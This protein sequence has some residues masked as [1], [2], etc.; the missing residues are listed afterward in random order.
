M[1]KIIVLIPMKKI[2]FAKSRLKNN[3]SNKDRKFLVF[4]LLDTL[5]KK[6]IVIKENNIEF[7]IA[8]VTHCNEIKKLIRENFYKK[9]LLINDERSKTLSHSMQVASS[10]ALKH[11]YGWICFLPG[12]LCSP[13][14]KDII[15]LLEFRSNKEEMTICPSN[16]YG[17]NALLLSIPTKFK[18]SF[19]KNSFYKHISFSK[20]IGLKTN[21]LNLESLNS[22]LDNLIS[23][24]KYNKQESLNLNIFNYE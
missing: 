13:K 6:L 16:D 9:I 23:L 15:K 4:K 11:S 1:K 2:D 8:I 18:F 3:L 17:T 7:D 19:G 5:V 21:I 14:T 22:D 24:R 12:D 20:K 10:W